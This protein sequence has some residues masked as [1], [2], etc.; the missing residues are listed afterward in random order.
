MD[1][2]A[3]HHL[4]AV[5]EKLMPLRGSVPNHLPWKQGRKCTKGLYFL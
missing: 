2:T 5:S 3:Q 1:K 4:L